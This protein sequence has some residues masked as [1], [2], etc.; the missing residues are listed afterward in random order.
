MNL[1]DEYKRRDVV[2][3]SF[4]PIDY[5]EEKIMQD[6]PEFKSIDAPNIKGDFVLFWEGETIVGNLEYIFMWINNSNFHVHACSKDLIM[7]NL[8]IHDYNTIWHESMSPV[9]ANQYK[10]EE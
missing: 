4:S 9:T 5:T 1:L 6:E 7:V 10:D 2:G 3:F 8:E